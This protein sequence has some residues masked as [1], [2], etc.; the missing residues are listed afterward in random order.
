MA[1]NLDTARFSAIFISAIEMGHENTKNSKSIYKTEDFRKIFSVQK[2]Q[3]HFKQPR[4][5]YPKYPDQF[6]HSLIKC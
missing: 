1:E 6:T 3:K 5:N 2:W 4:K